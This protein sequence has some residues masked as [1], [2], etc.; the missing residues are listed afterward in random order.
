MQL[1][2]INKSTTSTIQSNYST[3]YTTCNTNKQLDQ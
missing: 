1:Y 2:Y 3:I